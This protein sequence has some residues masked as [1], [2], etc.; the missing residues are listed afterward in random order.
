ML[1]IKS[2]FVVNIF[3]LQVLN[4]VL[5]IAEL[6]FKHSSQELRKAGYLSWR[7]LMD[8]FALDPQVLASSKRIKLITRPL[9]VSINLF[10]FKVDLTGERV[11]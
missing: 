11:R 3:Y 4:S 10:L 5:Q 6:A 2:M 9:V 1:R 7:I 8:N